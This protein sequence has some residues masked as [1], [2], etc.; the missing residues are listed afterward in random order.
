MVSSNS[1]YFSRLRW[2]IDAGPGF[3]DSALH[4]HDILVAQT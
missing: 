2:A 1:H 4:L 3:S